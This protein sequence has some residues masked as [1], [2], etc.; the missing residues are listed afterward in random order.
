[1]KEEHYAA[2]VD[3]GGTKTALCC[4]DEQGCVLYEGI[5]GPLNINGINLTEIRNT[6]EGIVF[7]LAKMDSGFTA[8]AGI[9]IATAGASNP[10]WREFVTRTLR[11]LGYNGPFDLKGDHEAALRG[12]VG[13]SGAVLVSGTGSICFGRNDEGQTARAGGWG[14]LLDDEGSGFAIGRDILRA[15]LRAVDG[16]EAESL[17]TKLVYDQLKAKNPE[18]IIRIVYAPDSGKAAIASLAPL[19]EPAC[20]QGDETAK[21]ILEN[22]AHELF[23]LYKAVSI[24]LRLKNNSLALAGGVLN[25]NLTLSDAVRNKLKKEFPHLKVIKP[26]NSPS[27]G[28]ADLARESY[29]AGQIKNPPQ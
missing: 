10:E 24:K 15:I 29:L 16:R 2:G 13:R 20:L 14:Y 12:A 11:D 6:L 4:V 28:A 7:Q 1:M 9:T 8:C 25:N 22:T 17:L 27:Y 23:L 19:L 21:R 18:D 26:L 5:F 3:G